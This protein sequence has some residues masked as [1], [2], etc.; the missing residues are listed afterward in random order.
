MTGDS[1]DTSHSS[2]L[3][4]SALDAT[5]ARIP[6][7]RSSRDLHEITP[8][9][10]LDVSSGVLHPL[11]YQQAR[12]YNLPVEGVYLA[13]VSQSHGQAISRRIRCIECFQASVSL[14]RL[15]HFPLQ[16]FVFLASGFSFDPRKSSRKRCTPTS[17]GYL[18]PSCRAFSVHRSMFVS[19]VRDGSSPRHLSTSRWDFLSI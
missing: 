18:S 11:S 5:F 1:L 10:Y 17:N 13:Q 2:C 9:E 3:F 8:S 15:P 12:N 4:F 14:G 16:S 6:L 7:P 19:D